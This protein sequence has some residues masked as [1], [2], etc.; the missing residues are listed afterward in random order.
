[1]KPPQIDEYVT[2]R[3]LRYLGAL[4]EFAARARFYLGYPQFLMIAVLFYYES[5]LIRETFPTIWSWAI[6]L[7]V[8]GL[9]AMA[10]EYTVVYPAQIVFNRGQGEQEHRSPLYKTVRENSRKLDRLL[11]GEQIMADGGRPECTTCESSGV[12]GVHRNRPVWECP[13]CEHILLR[14]IDR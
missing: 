14:D 5:S 4:R 9:G 3:Y 2:A 10:F 8:C 7:V 1:M 6:F 11:D 12:P 13:D